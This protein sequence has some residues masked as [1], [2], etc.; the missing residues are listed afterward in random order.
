MLGIRIQSPFPQNI[1]CIINS[2]HRFRLQLFPHGGTLSHFSDPICI[3]FLNSTSFNFKVTLTK[4]QRVPQRHFYLMKSV[5][6]LMRVKEQIQSRSD[7]SQLF[8]RQKA[9]D[10]GILPRDLEFTSQ[11]LQACLPW[12]II[13]LEK[14]ARELRQPKPFH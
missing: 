14:E 7:H 3:A 10:S 12:T 8:I 6:T 4:I 11:H 5:L 1:N 9:I 2:A 13:C